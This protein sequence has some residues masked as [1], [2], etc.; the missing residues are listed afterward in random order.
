M[1]HLLV[2]VLKA[3]AVIYTIGE[4]N[5]LQLVWECFL[6]VSKSYRQLSRVK[7]IIVKQQ[8]T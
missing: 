2:E 7:I 6:I 8:Q 4:K 5:A 1:H 3:I